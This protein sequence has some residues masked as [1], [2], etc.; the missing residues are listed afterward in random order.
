MDS[1]LLCKLRLISRLIPRNTQ[2]GMAPTRYASVMVL[3]RDLLVLLFYK[4]RIMSDVTIQV[5]S[6]TS[7]QVG[8]KDGGFG[9]FWWKGMDRAVSINR[10][11][12]CLVVLGCSRDSVVHGLV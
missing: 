11:E 5:L 2:T 3:V 9:S 12:D 4:L 6:G 7:R 10:C 1:I 8:L